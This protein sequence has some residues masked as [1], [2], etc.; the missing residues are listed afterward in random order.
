MGV[1]ESLVLIA[2][3]RNPL[4]LSRLLFVRQYGAERAI[5]RDYLQTQDAGL[6]VASITSAASPPS[7][8]LRVYLGQWPDV[9]S[10]ESIF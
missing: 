8:V 2:T 6:G 10:I 5:I 1:S 3:F 7:L 4:L 9:R